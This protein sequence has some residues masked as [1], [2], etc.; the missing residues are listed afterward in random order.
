MKI[1]GIDHGNSYVKTC[2]KSFESGL[3]VYQSKPEGE[4]VEW[5]DKFF[6][7]TPNRL[8]T[9]KD[10]TETDDFRVLTMF[11]IAKELQ[12]SHDYVPGMEIGLAVGLPPEHMIRE[13][14][15]KD[16][17]S[18]FT[19]KGRTMSFKYCG[20][21]YTV[22][23]DKVHVYPQGYAV[24]FLDPKLYKERITSYIVDIGGMTC[25]I[26]RLNKGVMDPSLRVSLDLG[27][28]TFFNEAKSQSNTALRYIP[29][30]GDILDYVISGKANKPELAKIF[31]LAF[32][33]YSTKV[34]NSLR[35]RGIDLRYD[36][37]TFCGGGSQLLKV[38]L[39]KAAQGN[40]GIKFIDDIKAN[41]KGYQTIM[42]A[43]LKNR[44]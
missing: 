14:S 32:E 9:Q 2:H 10:K 26:L 34:I 31:A 13:E 1:I 6:V 23:I 44:G 25:D 38:N 21:P 33:Q 5:N 16:W 24:V 4:C 7:L 42:E 37:I 41:A 35:E 22:K 29:N 36:T 27:V 39:E 20:K 43:K 3:H 15:V 17:G 19:S 18:Y 12:Y 28:I 30:E 40:K 11:A 8:E